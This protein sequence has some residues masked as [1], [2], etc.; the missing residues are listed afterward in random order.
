M[1]VHVELYR[2][3]LPCTARVEAILKPYNLL[4]PVSGRLPRFLLKI[5][6]NLHVVHSMHLLL[7]D[8][9]SIIIIACL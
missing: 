5:S 3:D 9:T 4:V 2:V 1:E 6:C 7:S 8:P